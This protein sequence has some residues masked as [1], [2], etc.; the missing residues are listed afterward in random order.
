MSARLRA[1]GSR[2]RTTD[3]G[4]NSLL[5]LLCRRFWLVLAK[6]RCGGRRVHAPG[7]REGCRLSG[8]QPG[9]SRRKVRTRCVLSLKIPSIGKR[10][11]RDVMLSIGAACAANTLNTLEISGTKLMS[12]GVTGVTNGRH[13]CGSDGYWSRPIDRCAPVFAEE[14]RWSRMPRRHLCWHTRR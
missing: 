3:P 5:A 2:V 11:A 1:A 9:S 8:L 7:Y 10:H 4:H 12:A 13:T 6:S 14:S